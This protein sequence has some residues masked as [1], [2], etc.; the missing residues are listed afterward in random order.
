MTAGKNVNIQTV[1][2]LIV[3]GEPAVARTCIA[4]TVPT[5]MTRYVTAVRLETNSVDNRKGTRLY[6]VSTAA[7]G[8]ASTTILASAGAKMVIEVMSSVYQLKHKMF[9]DRIDTENPL[10]SIAA[11]KYLSV[12]KSRLQCGSNPATLFV[13]YYD[14]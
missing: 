8:S 4:S 11:G 12:H 3:T 7:K 2:R 1:R 10:F 9:P 6:L 5:G 13:Q 14:Q